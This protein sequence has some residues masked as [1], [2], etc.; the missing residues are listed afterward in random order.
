MLSVIIP[1]RNGA[2]TIEQCL[3]ALFA[4]RHDDF[5]VIV[6]DDCSTDDSMERIKKYP[7]RYYQLNSHGCASMARNTGAR[8]S[9][10][11]ILFFLDADCLTTVD[12][13]TLAEKFARHHGPSV[14]IGGTYTEI[15]ADPCFFST[16]QS[17][18]INYCEIKHSKAPDYIATHAMVIHTETFRK[19]GGFREQFLPILEDVELSHRLRHNG[20]RL[21][22]APSIL[23]RHVFN[24]TLRRS[25]ANAL[26][27]S[28]YWTCYSL[29]NHDIFADSGTASLELKA[30]VACFVAIVLLVLFSL[31]VPAVAP[32]LPLVLPLLGLNGIIQRHLLQ[33]FFKA[34]GPYFAIGAGLYYCFV[35]PLAVASGGV[36]GICLYFR[37]K[38]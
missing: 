5:E 29:E 30:N 21:L 3:S 13:L 31:L 7:C 25:L 23:V 37:Q 28:L 19:A 11:D 36:A 34:G 12:T 4:S 8:H 24:F 15:P 33:A 14:A 27:K 16:F 26:R 1:N 38:H 9:R 32:F 18:Y 17:I 6:V 22:M 20:V 35:Y 2:A 10:G